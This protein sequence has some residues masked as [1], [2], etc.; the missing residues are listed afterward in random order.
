MIISEMLKVENISTDLKAKN[1]PEILK[2]LVGLV[3]SGNILDEEKFLKDFEQREEAGSTALENG[4]AIPHVRSEYIEKFTIGV[5]TNREGVDFDSI[6]GKKT[7]VFVVIASPM[8]ERH[9]HLEALAK[10]AAILYNPTN[11]EVISNSNSK[12]GIID[13]ISKLESID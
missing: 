2:E 7:K 6:D 4:L 12:E 8:K 5:A 13:L 9:L 10:V 11:V 1:K 3:K